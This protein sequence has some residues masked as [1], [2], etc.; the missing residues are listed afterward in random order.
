MHARA[1]GAAPLQLSN[2]KLSGEAA[3][4]LAVPRTLEPPYER[5]AVVL[6]TASSFAT[7]G[8]I[9]LLENKRA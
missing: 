8:A 1:A 5:V 7:R 3:S 9:D 4:N 6:R 2:M